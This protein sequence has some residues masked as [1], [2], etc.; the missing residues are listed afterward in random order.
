MSSLNVAMTRFFSGS[1]MQSRTWVM[2]N[3]DHNGA[4]AAMAFLPQLTA[5]GGHPAHHNSAIAASA[6]QV[7]TSSSA[8]TRPPQTSFSLMTRP[9]V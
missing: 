1:A 3:V 6:S 2:V 8:G 5:F 4:S 7:L 9:G